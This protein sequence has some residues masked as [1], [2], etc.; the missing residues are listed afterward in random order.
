MFV[1]VAVSEMLLIICAL[2][3]YVCKIHRIIFLMSNSSIEHNR[4]EFRVQYNDN[5]V[6]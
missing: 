6:S 3:L 1:V 2:F 5:S 4:L